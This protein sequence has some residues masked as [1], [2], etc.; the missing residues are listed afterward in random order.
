VTS[1]D[2]L[3]GAGATQ[4]HSMGDRFALRIGQRPVVVS[5]T[6]VIHIH[7]WLMA[8]NFSEPLK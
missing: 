3:H 6:S 1:A 2:L 7:G 8:L 4:P 5:S